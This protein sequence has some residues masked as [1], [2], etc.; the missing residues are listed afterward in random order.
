MAPCNSSR[1]LAVV[2]HPEHTRAFGR[3]NTK[4]H[5]QV[6]LIS[7]HWTKKTS[8]ILAVGDIQ[9][10]RRRFKTGTVF[11]VQDPADK[12]RLK[13]KHMRHDGMIESIGYLPID[14]GMYLLK[15]A[16]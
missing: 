6:G 8:F 14:L 4:G 2:S 1:G 3:R 11:D 7:S 10:A 12:F 5:P 16:R 9:I 15:A 13:T